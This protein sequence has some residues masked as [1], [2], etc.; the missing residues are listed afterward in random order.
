MSDAEAAAAKQPDPMEKFH[1]LRDAY[2]EI[3]SK[4]LIDTVNSD[5]YAQASGAA[6]NSFLTATAPFK[7]PAEQA[8]LKTLQQL[9]VPTSADFAVLAGRF[10]NVEMQLDNL[11]AKLDRIEK[12]LSG[13]KPASPVQ[14]V[15]LKSA[16]ASARPVAPRSARK[17]SQRNRPS[18]RTRG[19]PKKTTNA[20][21]GRGNSRKRTK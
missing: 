3:W 6:L 4:H 1:E 7:E 16:E 8:M 13:A 11:D 21:P 17:T 10:T 2:L 14:E 19:T 9:N 18:L 5:S 20:K 12:L 15:A